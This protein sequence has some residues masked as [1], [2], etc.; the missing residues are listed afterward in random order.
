SSPDS[1]SSPVPCS[2]TRTSSSAGAAAS[3]NVRVGLSP[4]VPEASGSWAVMGCVSSVDDGA[5][6]GGATSIVAAGTD[7]R[8]LRP[9][10]GGRRGHGGGR[11]SG[12]PLGEP[13]D[14]REMLRA[15]SA[16]V[17]VEL[18]DGDLLVRPGVVVERRVDGRGRADGIA[19][20]DRE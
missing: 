7:S 10:V 12:E 1:T 15:L 5:P 9:S 8:T 17:L 20:R 2:R 14:L 16:L 13:A 11:G 18:V 19:E 4:K 6:D 3:G